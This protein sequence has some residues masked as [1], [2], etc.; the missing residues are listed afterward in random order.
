MQCLRVH[1]WL[2]RTLSDDPV[3]KEMTGVIING[4]GEKKIDS[5]RSEMKDD[6][7]LAQTTLFRHLDLFQLSNLISNATEQT[8]PA[9]HAMLR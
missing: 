7:T 8:F 4:A 5:Q 2:T 3:E 1:A 9:G 6:A